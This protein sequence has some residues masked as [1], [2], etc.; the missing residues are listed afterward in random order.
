MSIHRRNCLSIPLDRKKLNMKRMG[1]ENFKRPHAKVKLSDLSSSRQASERRLLL[2]QQVSS[3][4]REDRNL[5]RMLKERQSFE[6]FRRQGFRSDFDS[7]IDVVDYS[8]LVYENLDKKQDVVREKQEVRTPSR[9][10]RLE[11]RFSLSAGRGRVQ[12]VETPGASSAIRS[13]SPM[14]ISSSTS[15][16]S[17]RP[18]PALSLTREQEWLR[19]LRM[20]IQEATSYKS[21]AGDVETPTFDRLQKHVEEQVERSLRVDNFPPLTRDHLAVVKSVL[22]VQSGVVASRFNIDLG[23]DDIRR[24]RDGQWL[25]DELINYY[26]NMIKERS[27]LRGKAIHTFSTFFYPSIKDIGYSK[28]KRWTKKVDLFALDLVLFPV[29]LGVHWCC[30]CVDMKKKRIEYYDSLHGLDSKFFKLI[31]SYLQ[32]E[33]MD[34]RKVELDLTEWTDYAPKNI[35]CQENGYDCGVFTCIFAEYRS[36]CVEFDFAQEHMKY[37]RN[38]MVY[39]IKQGKLMIK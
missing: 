21:P 2:L 26:F 7:F 29:H 31:R 32:Q 30:G 8:K 27:E 3:V 13:P 15:V 16:R 37:L 34:K 6:S 5:D 11:R 25:N 23:P 4:E 1:D 19:Q 12:R 20:K 18:V 38:R 14:S 17:I 9:Q 24:L 33:S 36:R 28:V 10:E 39:E 35:P 22:S